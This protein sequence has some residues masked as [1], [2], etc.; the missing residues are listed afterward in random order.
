M[1]ECS[2][3]CVEVKGVLNKHDN[4]LEQLKKLVENLDV[5]PNE[6]YLKRF[7]YGA[8]F[9]VDEAFKKIKSSKEHMLD[10]H[11]WY[12]KDG[13]LKLKEFIEKDIRAVLP[14]CD[15]DGRPI[16]L[17]KN[18]NI[19]V[20]TMSLFD[21]VAVDDVWIESILMERPEAA[22]KGLCV[23]IDIK[24]QSWKLSKWMQPNLI[25]QSIRKTDNL[26]FKDFKVHVVN[27]SWWIS[28][29]IKMMWPFLPQKFKDMMHF[30]FNNL[31]SF[32]EYIDKEVLP[33][34]YGGLKEVKYA[35]LYEKLYERN[36]QIFESFSQYRNYKN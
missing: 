13:P 25:K 18:G 2:S 17:V 24:D 21:V 14:D 10:Q 33:I 6:N 26:P 16:Y 27:N 30:H 8:D 31:E 19:D 15:K 28:I 34:E 35:Q 20:S 36:D 11:D 23:I 22:A 3:D 1:I 5:I 4:A 9:N 12:R 32:Y 29:G 7:L